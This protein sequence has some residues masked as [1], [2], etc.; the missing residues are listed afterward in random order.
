MISRSSR[1]TSPLSTGRGI[2][3]YRRHPGNDRSQPLGSPGGV[4]TSLAEIQYSSTKWLHPEDVVS[5]I[6][7]MRHCSEQSGKTAP[8]ANIE[9]HAAMDP[10]ITGKTRLYGLVGDP[11]TA[12]RSPQL[13]NQVFA[14]QHV[15]AACVPFWVKAGNLSGF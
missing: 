11:L 13:L 4:M 3:T 12:A 9:H 6:P 10:Y 15:D 14:E 7:L 5:D 8:S 1:S 2:W